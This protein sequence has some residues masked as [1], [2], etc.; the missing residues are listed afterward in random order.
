MPIRA[1]DDQR[2]DLLRAELLKIGLDWDKQYRLVD[3]GPRWAL[4]YS[5]HQLSSI[6]GCR[7]CSS[8]L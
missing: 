2:L 3:E 8:E 4:D 1:D 7:N 6:S 5:Q